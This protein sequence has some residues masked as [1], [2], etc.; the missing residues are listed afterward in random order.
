VRRGSS[1]FQNFRAGFKERIVGNLPPSLRTFTDEFRE[2]SVATANVA[3]MAVEDASI[4]V[5]VEARSIVLVEGAL[6][7]SVPSSM[8]GLKV[9]M[10]GKDVL[11]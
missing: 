7:E 4:Q 3:A 9:Q 10:P 5:N 2:P 8:K 11:W 6:D 1:T